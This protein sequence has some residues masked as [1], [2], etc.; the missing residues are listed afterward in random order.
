MWA[1]GMKP[2]YKL[3]LI[4][5]LLAL[6]MQVNPVEAEQKVHRVQQGENLFSI[7]EKFGVRVEKL[8][9]NNKYLCLPNALARNLLLVIPDPEPA[10]PKTNSTNPKPKPATP[11][12]D[13][14]DPSQSAPEKAAAPPKKSL[15]MILEELFREYK[16]VVFLSGPSRSNKIALTF[17]D[18][19]T[20]VT[21]SQVLDILQQNN[22]KATFFL[23]GQ[24]IDRYPQVV[25]RIVREGHVVAGHS[26]SHIQLEKAQLPRIIGEV[27]DTENAIYQIAGVR[28]ALLRPPYGSLNRE[29]LEYLRQNGY[30]V[31]N[32]S[33]DSLDWKY[34]DRGN[35][36]IIST[37]RDVRGG[38]II[39]FHT[40]PGKDPS[41]IIGKVLP[42]II[43]S[44]K[45]QGY[46][47]VTV[48]QLLSIPAY[49]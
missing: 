29:G 24:N 20:E 45:S 30:K 43:Y 12:T 28:P 44:L 41:P 23:L 35:Q 15:Q 31:V 7:A 42:E 11:Q 18:G 9:A 36:V 16:D 27:T 21:S 32:W 39:L 14:K 17:D 13:K 40:L 2:T 38:S 33:V 26:W 8:L 6:L 5:V 22:V 1:K 4:G 47:F 46:Q 10:P 48:D 37:L 3:L 25:A 19:P 49:K 34:P